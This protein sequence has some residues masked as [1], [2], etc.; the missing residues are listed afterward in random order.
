MDYL[1][2]VSRVQRTEETASSLSC[3]IP[4]VGDASAYNCMQRYNTHRS[5]PTRAQ[6]RNIITFCRLL[7]N[8]TTSAEDTSSD[9][10]RRDRVLSFRLSG[11][12]SKGCQAFFILAKLRNGILI[13]CSS[14]SLILGSSTSEGL[15]E[16]WIEMHHRTE[17]KTSAGVMVLSTRDVPTIGATIPKASFVASR[18]YARD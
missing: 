18:F 5:D 17:M 1:N 7:K 16:L 10:R 6:Y 14:F 4:S 9:T 2:G 12:S 11:Q 3:H 8:P 15:I 13:F